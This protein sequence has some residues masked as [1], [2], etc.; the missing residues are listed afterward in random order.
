RRREVD[1]RAKSMTLRTGRDASPCALKRCQDASAAWSA[2]GCSPSASRSSVASRSASAAP[3]AAAR[4]SMTATIAPI[5]EAKDRAPGAPSHAGGS[6]PRGERLSRHSAEREERDTVRPG[7]DLALLA[8]SDAREH[9]GLER[10]RLASGA[11]LR[12]P[13]DRDV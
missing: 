1:G 10:E 13:F 7:D 8:G 11:Q 12:A 4:A 6:A 2:S 3:D 9:T 5:E